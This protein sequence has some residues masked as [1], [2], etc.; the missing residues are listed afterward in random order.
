MECFNAALQKWTPVDALATKTIAK[1]LKL[2]P[3]A[4]DAENSMTYVVAFEE[5]GVARDVTKRYTKAFNAK[6][7]KTRVEATPG[8]DVWWRMAMRYYARGFSLV[9]VRSKCK[10][11]APLA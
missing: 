5:D 7:R 2:E 8:G 11:W 6:T 10:M 9:S 3:P 1:A 4:G